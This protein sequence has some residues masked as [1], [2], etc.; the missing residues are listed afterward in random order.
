[1]SAI[2]LVTPQLEAVLYF[3][4]CSLRIDHG[5]GVW[6]GGGALPCPSNPDKHSHRRLE[7]CAGGGEVW[8]GEG[9]LYSS[10]HSSFSLSFCPLCIR[11]GF[12]EK[13][14]HCG[15]E[16]PPSLKSPMGHGGPGHYFYRAMP[17][18]CMAQGGYER[19]QNPPPTTP[20]SS[21][22]HWN[23]IPAPPS[24]LSVFLLCCLKILT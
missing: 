18:H 7:Q 11:R 4:R 21:Y 24:P 17:S 6:G 20:F 3:C 19:Y 22:H 13:F 9:L 10:P 14:A 8:E 5:V 15:A 23:L 1:M 16:Q 2:I 12:D